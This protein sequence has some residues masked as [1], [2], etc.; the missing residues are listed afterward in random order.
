[1]AADC[2]R[3]VRLVPARATAGV[4][5]GASVAVDPEAPDHS[6]LVARMRSRRPSSQMPPLGTVL[7]DQAA[8]DAIVEWIRADLAPA[9]SARR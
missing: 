7:R 4:A 6:A 8:V 9:R 5:E 2:T 3:R 1:M